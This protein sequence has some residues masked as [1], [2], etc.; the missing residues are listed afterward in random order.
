MCYEN[1]SA[2]VSLSKYGLY[3][4][5]ECQFSNITFPP[6]P[7]HPAP[8]PLSQLPVSS[9]GKGFSGAG[10]VGSDLGGEGH[11]DAHFQCHAGAWEGSDLSEVCLVSQQLGPAALRVLGISPRPRAVRPQPLTC[12]VLLR[13]ETSLPGKEGQRPWGAPEPGDASLC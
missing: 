3:L 4:P 13:A 1:K 12:A 9:C 8:S 10:S 7:Y 2:P 5:V 11:R 6:L